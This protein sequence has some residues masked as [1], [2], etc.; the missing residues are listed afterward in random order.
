MII[1]R[2]VASFLSKDAGS[3]RK[4]GALYEK[5]QQAV[6]QQHQQ[7]SPAVLSILAVSEG[8][9]ESRSLS[10]SLLWALNETRVI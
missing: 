10:L 6:E 9:I 1:A 7:D 5:H 2:F 8:E 3:C 4:A